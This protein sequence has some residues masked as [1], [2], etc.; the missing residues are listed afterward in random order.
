MGRTSKRVPKY[1]VKHNFYHNSNRVLL[2]IELYKDKFAVGD[3]I[4][5]TYMNGCR[6][7]YKDGCL[8]RYKVVFIDDL[9]MAF[10]RMIAR[11]RGYI[12]KSTT[13][14]YL[15]TQFGETHASYMRFWHG[16]NYKDKIIH[17]IE[18]DEGYMNAVMLGERFDP[19][20]EYKARRGIIS[21]PK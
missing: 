20:A 9:G 21:A 17:G 10:V 6:V 7:P 8:R 11:R 13:P 18:F 14:A 3:I 16:D 19:R 4:N 1:V 12:K 5:L 15:L 2:W